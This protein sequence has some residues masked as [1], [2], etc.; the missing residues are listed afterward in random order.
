MYQIKA[1]ILCNKRIISGHYKMRLHAPGIAQEAKPGQFVHIRTENGYNPLLRRPFGIHGCQD[2]EIEILYKVVGRGTQAL[3]GKKIGNGIDILGP[4]GQGFKI[5]PDSGRI[6]LVAGGMGIA[7]LCFLAEK[8]SGED[9]LVLV[10]AESAGKVLCLERFEMLNAKI[11]IA[12]EDGSKGFK[13]MLGELFSHFLK[14]NSQLDLVYACGPMPMLRRIAQLS[15]KYK[16]PCQV[17]LEQKMACGMGACLGCTIEGKNSYL[18]ACSDGP[19]FQ[20]QQILWNK[21]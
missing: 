15:L 1:K 6:V 3:A 7:P 13:G 11:Q 16:I 12:T 4:L 14:K 19:V 17:S 20:A 21:V 10:G 2:E 9:I 18:R 8:L 5:D